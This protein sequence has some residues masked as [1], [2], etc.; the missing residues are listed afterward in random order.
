M[1]PPDPDLAAAAADFKKG[2][3]IVALLGV[4]GAMVR[5]LLT[6]KR[7]HWVC[8]VKHAI[9]GGLV[10]V[11]MY[12]A[13]HGTDIDPLYKSVLLSSSGAIAPRLFEYLD[14]KVREFIKQ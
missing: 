8:W 6:D 3:W 5:M 2:G 10:G 4:A 7:H 14:A 9:A 1:N 13:L 12:F 11:I